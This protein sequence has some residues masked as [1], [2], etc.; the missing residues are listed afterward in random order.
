MDPASLHTFLKHF[1]SNACDLSTLSRAHSGTAAQRNSLPSGTSN[2]LGDREPASMT[3]WQ[4]MVFALALVCLSSHMMF[5]QQIVRVSD[6]D[7]TNPA[8]VSIA[9]NPKN[10]D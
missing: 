9:I 4:R 6:A 7:A 8:E 3:S 2:S 10:P 1:R 5:A